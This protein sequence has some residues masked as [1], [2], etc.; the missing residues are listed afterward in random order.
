MTRATGDVAATSGFDIARY[1][2]DI[3]PTTAYQSVIDKS[4]TVRAEGRP[5]ELV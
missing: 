3:T 1:G 2:S 5:V 4:H